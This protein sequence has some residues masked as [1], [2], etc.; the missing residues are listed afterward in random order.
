[1]STMI[2]ATS[3]MFQRGKTVVPKEVRE[4]LGVKD[5]D[6]LVWAWNESRGTVEL[7]VNKKGVRYSLTI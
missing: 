1:M 6:T 5:G 2:I 7:V 4:R 3:K